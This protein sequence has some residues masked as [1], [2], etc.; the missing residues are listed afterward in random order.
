MDRRLPEL[1][2]PLD[3]ADDHGEAAPIG[4]GRPDNSSEKL[5]RHIPIFV[6][7]H[8]I[9]SLAA[10]SIGVISTKK[11]NTAAAVNIKAKLRLIGIAFQYWPGKRLEHIPRHSFSLIA[12][13]GN[14]GKSQ[15]SLPKSMRCTLTIAA[16]TFWGKLKLGNGFRTVPKPFH[17]K[18]CKLNKCKL[19]TKSL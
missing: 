3:G 2:A 17:V 1:I 13:R 14:I 15:P 8:P 19:N 10:Q 9:K 18:Q 6:Q 4:K 7:N 11:L 5:R 12:Q 16:V